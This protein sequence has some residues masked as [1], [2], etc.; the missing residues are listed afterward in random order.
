MAR[1]LLWVLP[2]RD[3]DDRLRTLP[4]RTEN[5]MKLNRA[6]LWATAATAAVMVLGAVTVIGIDRSSDENLPPA[7]AEMADAVE[8]DPTG[9]TAN[10]GVEEYR[11]GGAHGGAAHGVS[12]GG[13]GHGSTHGGG[14]GFGY[15]RGGYGHGWGGGSRWGRWGGGRYVGGRW[16][17]GPYYGWCDGRYYACNRFWG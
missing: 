2:R 13:A 12:H 4:R 6:M 5:D 10:A 15:G 9:T 1:R 14:R 17:N 3:D 16:V 7:G 11:G 8:G